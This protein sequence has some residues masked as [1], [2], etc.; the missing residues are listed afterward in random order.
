EP[1]RTHGLEG[2]LAIDED[3]CTLGESRGSSS[4]NRWIIAEIGNDIGHAACMDH[5]LGNVSDRRRQAREI[6]LRTDDRERFGIDPCR[7]AKIGD[8]RAG[9]HSAAPQGTWPERMI[10]MRIGIPLVVVVIVRMMMVVVI[11]M[12]VVMRMRM[13]LRVLAG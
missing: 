1:G 8:G 11:V 12:M 2:Y 4:G 5:P 7:I 9:D 6:G 10:G 3:R 13:I